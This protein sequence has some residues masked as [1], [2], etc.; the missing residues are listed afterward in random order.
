MTTKSYLQQLDIMN[1]SINEKLDEIYKLRAESCSIGVSTNSDKIIYSGDNDKMGSIVSKIVDMENE[2]DKIIDKYSDLR[3]TI[4]E[5]I[6]SINEELYRHVL[7]KRYVKFKTFGE[8]AKEIGMTRSGTFKLHDRALM[9]FEKT[10]NI[11]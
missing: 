5:Q 4:I 3:D 8:I 2:T 10:Q 9:K 11:V 1:T 7:Y 6:S